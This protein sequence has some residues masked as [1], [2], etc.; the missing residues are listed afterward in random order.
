MDPG[1]RESDDARTVAPKNVQALA[2]A[3]DDF[4]F[5][6]QRRLPTEGNLVLSPLSVWLTL[7]TLV[8]GSRGD[9]RKELVAALAGG[10]TSPP[11][12][13]V[14][15]GAALARA[16][17]RRTETRWTEDPDTGEWQDGPVE[18]FVLEIAT[19]LWAAEG[20]PFHE[21]YLRTLVEVMEAEAGSLDFTDALSAARRVNAWAEERTRGRI[22]S[23][24]SPDAVDPRTRLL[25]ANAT[26]FKAGWLA[27]FPKADTR[28]APF[29][30]PGGPVEVEMMEGVADRGYA[31]LEDPGLEV[32]A[33]PY[34]AV[35]ALLILPDAGA[36]GRLEGAL[37]A[38]FVQGLWADLTMRKVT[39][40]LPRFDFASSLALERVLPDL[41]V[42]RALGERA[43]FSGISP[44]PE[45]LTLSGA[46]HEACIRVDEEGTEA[47]AVTLLAMAGLSE[48]QEAPE[49]VTVVVDRPFLFL[50][51]DPRTNAVLFTARVTDPTHPG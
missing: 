51:R 47:A 14:Q 42:R 24:L 8:P 9:T 33:L 46:I 23:V 3:L 20:Y 32:V 2:G 36:M 31:R 19:A 22:S 48:P 26:Y 11:D 39:L 17:R 40:H 44:H 28:P 49:A 41:G 50:V 45:G 34:D 13:L 21:A 1:A 30:A 16:L 27:P 43:D 15:A 38:E 4:G 25:L 5:E 35:E 7:L 12:D 29:H 37:D 10:W 18:L 6:L